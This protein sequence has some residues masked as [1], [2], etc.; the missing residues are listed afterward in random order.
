[1]KILLAADG[2]AF[3]KKALTFLVK[4]MNLL[5]AGDELIVLHVQ[6]EISAQVQ[7][8]LSSADVTAYQ[9]KH[10][11]LVLKPIKKFLD[12]NEVNYRSRW[13]VGEP[14]KQIIDTSKR[15]HVRM[16]VMGSHGQG[17]MSRIFV[18]SVAQRVLAESKIP[19]LLVK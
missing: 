11:E 17:F 6:D 19:I 16:I 9:T 15:E 1:M 14:S 5:T 3:T 2:S 10:A 7:R 4:E 8:M 12:K 13:V 18:G